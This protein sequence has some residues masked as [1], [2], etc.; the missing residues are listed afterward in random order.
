[1]EASAAEWQKS[2]LVGEVFSTKRGKDRFGIL[3]NRMSVKKKSAETE[4]ED[5][6]P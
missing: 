2:L 5:V 4:S 3:S 6:D 1:M